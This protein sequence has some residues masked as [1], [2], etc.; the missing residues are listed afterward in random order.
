MGH[1]G[2]NGMKADRGM[3]GEGRR[4]RGN[5]DMPQE[6]QDDFGG[7]ET[8]WDMSDESDI[9]RKGM[10]SG[11][12]MILSGGTFSV[13]SY[14]DAFHSNGSVAVS[15]GDFSVETGDDGIHAD[16]ELNIS[17]GTI[18]ITKSYEGLEGN[19]IVINHAEIEIVSSDDGINAYGGQNSFGGGSSKKTEETPDLRISGG[20]LLID[21][22][23]DGIDSNGNLTI[24]GGNIVVNGPVRDG[25]GAIDSGSENGGIC[26]ISGGTILALGS[27]GMAETFSAES[28]QCSFLHNFDS[29]FSKE[30]KSVFLTAVERSY[31]TI[32]P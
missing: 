30:V 18:K 27:S 1:F 21:A 14:D 8:N 5:Q 3:P 10:K 12:K 6:G 31:I 16:G 7:G 15:N 20:T 9:S 13:D 24:E 2:G 28:K 25:N 26:T 23:G 29:A 32:L 17:G 11:K 19:Q 4:P 22:E